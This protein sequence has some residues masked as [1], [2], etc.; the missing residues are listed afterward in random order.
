MDEQKYISDLAEIKSLMNKSSKFM[1][2]SGFSGIL[3][4]VYALIAAFLAAKIIYGGLD[5]SQWGQTITLTNDQLINL[6]IVGI[7]TLFL[8]IGTG[9]ILSVRKARQGGDKFWDNSSI[10]L[11][12]NFLIP[13]ITGA[14]F[15]LIL[16]DRHQFSLVGP[17]TLIF[18]GLSCVHA[19]KYTI[20]GVRYLGITMIVLGLLATYFDGYGLLF[21]A[22][23]FGICHIFY[24]TLMYF[25]QEK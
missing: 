6:S 14:I 8:A 12:L 15:C 9:V 16:I 20:G 1:S 13:L 5:A 10:R 7:V 17:L 21:W 18:Y 25:L 24:G 11:I 23:G 22:I 3:A 2:I 4:G 19:S